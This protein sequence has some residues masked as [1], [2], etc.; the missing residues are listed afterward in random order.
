M[1]YEYLHSQK[2]DIFMIHL[3]YLTILRFNLI[4]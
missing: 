3:T 2:I 1:Q 4:R